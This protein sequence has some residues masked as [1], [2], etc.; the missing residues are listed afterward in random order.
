MAM[1]GVETPMDGGR[2]GGLVPHEWREGEYLITTDPARVDLDV[3]HGFLRRSYWAEGIG[4]GLVERA[5]RHSLPFSV[6]AGERQVG[7]A[8]VVTDYAT[9]AWVADVFILEP[10]RGRGLSKWLVR[11]ML[12][13]PELQGLRRWILAT[14]DAHGL[15]RAHGFAPLAHPDRYLEILRPDA[16]RR[17]PHA[18]GADAAADAAAGPST[19]TAPAS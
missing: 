16:H 1:T 10:W 13:H 11:T 3:V 8:R 9:F 12:A 6:Y 17:P 18:A 2:T 15:Y 7:F 4:R 14:H 19:P 5:V